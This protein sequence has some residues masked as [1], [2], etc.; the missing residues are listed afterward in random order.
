[1]RS[2][3]TF[4]QDTNTNT[5]TQKVINSRILGISTNK[6]TQGAQQCQHTQTHTHTHMNTSDITRHLPNKI[7]Q[8][9][10]PRQQAEH[11]QEAEE[12]MK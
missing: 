3:V 11:T 9:G 4:Q 1:M 2:R 10:A 6:R 5:Y 7:N 8:R 12:L